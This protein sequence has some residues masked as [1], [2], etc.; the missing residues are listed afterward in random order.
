MT[1]WEAYALF[2]HEFVA[3][4]PERYPAEW[5]DGQVARGEWLCWGTEK[6]AIL[7]ELRRYPS[8]VR[9]VHGIA[10]A[11][12]LKAIIQLIALAEDFGRRN[13]CLRA[14]IESRPGWA[15]VLPDYETH[16]VS[17]RKELV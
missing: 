10:A 3:L 16:Q 1:G 6:A 14:V 8:G 13:G 2:R 4:D 7:A 12:N 5:I 11:G 9:E 17:V 15:K